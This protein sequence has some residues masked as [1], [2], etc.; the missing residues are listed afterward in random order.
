MNIRR[1][2]LLALIALLLAVSFAMVQPF[3]QY[4]LLALLLAFVLYPLQRRLE[5]EIGDQLSAA[6]L[7]VGA[8]FAFFV[9]FV[10]IGATV[11]GDAMQLAQQLQS[12][13][14][15]GF[16]I[17]RVESLI[18]QYTGFQVDL[19]SRVGQYAERAAQIVAGNVAGVLGTISHLLIGLG[20]GLFVLY[21]LLKDGNR[22]M[23]WTRETMPLPEG[24]Q[25]ELYASLDEITWAVLLGHVLVAMTQGAI[26]GIGLFVVGIPN[27][28]LW[29]FL[30][31][32]LSL[33]PIVG[34]FLVWG[35]AAIYLAMTGQTAFGVGLALYGL[36]VV[37]ATDNF[38]RPILVD[39]HAEINPSLIIVGVVGGVYLIGF[40]GLFVGPILVGALKVV[41]ELFEE[42]YEAL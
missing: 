38:L 10:V 39:R 36:V 21:Y 17:E 20:L 40:M 30:M 8:V 18:Q 2:F 9:P 19:A 35:P 14:F 25:D 11:A 42:H 31:I 34:S 15:S 33:I 41:L 1:G 23:A 5:P 3:L 7:V 22:L 26:A 32:V 28:T 6:V 29:T 12:G 13:G 4:L 16:G 27:A 37:S 24:I